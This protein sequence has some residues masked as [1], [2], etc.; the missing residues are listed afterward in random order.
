MNFVIPTVTTL[1]MSDEKQ[2]IKIYFI[3][4]VFALNKC[5]MIN[6]LFII[7]SLPCPN[8]SSTKVNNEIMK[9]NIN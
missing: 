7:T 5:L 4:N 3:I 8:I 2:K 9:N 6:R 1:K